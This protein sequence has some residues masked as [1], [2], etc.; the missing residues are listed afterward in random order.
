MRRG[1]SIATV[2]GDVT[3]DNEILTDEYLSRD[4]GSDSVVRKNAG[5]LLLVP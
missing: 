5:A 4:V 3:Q 2:R 1:V